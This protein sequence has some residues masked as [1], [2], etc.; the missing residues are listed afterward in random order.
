MVVDKPTSKRRYDCDNTAC[1]SEKPARL[2]ASFAFSKA[3]RVPTVDA[4]FFVALF[5]MAQGRAFCF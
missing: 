5:D 3:R 4:I 1:P 2:I